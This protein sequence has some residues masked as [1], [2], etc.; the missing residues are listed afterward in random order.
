MNSVGS[1]FPDPYKVSVMFR[2]LQVKECFRSMSK[3]HLTIDLLQAAADY[4]I[5]FSVLQCELNEANFVRFGRA[6]RTLERAALALFED[7]SHLH[8]SLPALL[9]VAV[10]END[11]SIQ[12]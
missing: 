3:K 6:A 1:R 8:V 5:A 9:S 11:D 2:C 12:E 7:A 10:A 4:A